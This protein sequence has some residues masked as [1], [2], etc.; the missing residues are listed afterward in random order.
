[1][2]GASDYLH[3]LAA[4]AA[5]AIASRDWTAATSAIGRSAV[6]SITIRT[7]VSPPFTVDPF[8]PT[9]PDAPTNPLLSWL[10]P[11][12]TIETASGALVMAPYGTPTR[13]HLPGLLGGIVLLGIGAVI[14]IGYAARRIGR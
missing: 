9:Q 13:N 10:K 3:P 4:G 6:R 8:A 11:E 14:G 2:P 12:V 7:Q 1:M 5:E